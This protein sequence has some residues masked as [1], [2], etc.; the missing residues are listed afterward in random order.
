MALRSH[1]HG[2]CECIHFYREEAEAESTLDPHFFQP[3]GSSGKKHFPKVDFA[4]VTLDISESQNFRS[5]D[6]FYLDFIVLMIC[7]GGA[8]VPLDVIPRVR[9]VAAAS[10]KQP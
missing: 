6:L 4:L 3:I 7:A 10:S 5:A 8:F 9:R 2:V 1:P